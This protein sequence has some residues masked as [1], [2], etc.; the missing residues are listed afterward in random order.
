M[1]DRLYIQNFRCLE[2]VTFDFAGRPSALVIGRN[3]VGKSTVRAS[4]ALVQRLC[5]GTNDVGS[6][7]AASDFTH[8]STDRPMRFEVGLT[9]GGR[10]FQ[11]AISFDWPPGFR[12]ARILDES[13]TLDDGI[14]FARHHSDVA[15]VT[16]ATF[17]LSWHICALPIIEERHG[18]RAIQDVKAF[19]AGMI[20]VAPIPAEM[21][22]YSDGPSFALE[23]DA[24]NYASCLRALLGQRPAAYSI[25][26]R[27]LKEVMPDFSS[28]ENVERGPKG[29][30]L[31]VKFQ[32]DDPPRTL[33]L[34]FASLSDGEKCFFLSAY[35]VASNVSGSPVFCMWDEPD[36]HLSLSEVGQFITGL[37]KMPGT[38]GQFIATTHHPETIRKFSDEN[39]FVLT[40]KS[41]LDPTLPRLL[42]EFAYG[43]DLVD[44]LIRDEIIG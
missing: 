9:L 33:A 18:G 1:I 38:G 10:R 6:L 5:R 42:S 4:L 39:T 20:L 30:Q 23:H 26:D 28:I 12:D 43:T 31:I 34:D 32:T 36:N 15:L 7:I 29:T 21:T 13:L 37:R 44:A 14:I 40:R 3:G 11:Y 27:Y 24:A 17:G 25:F 22:G 19:F 41:H 16:G 8:H 35:I 2:S